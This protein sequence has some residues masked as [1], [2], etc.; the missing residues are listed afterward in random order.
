MASA[1][2]ANTLRQELLGLVRKAFSGILDL[3]QGP[4]KRRFFFEN[5]QLLAAQSSAPG[6]TLCDSLAA[7]GV[8]SFDQRDQTLQ[9]VRAQK[10]SVDAA[11]LALGFITADKLAP[12]QSRHALSTLK[13]AVQSGATFQPTQRL[14]LSAKLKAIPVDATGVLDVR[15]EAIDIEENYARMR[16]QDFYE[17]L[18]VEEMATPDQVRQAYFALAKRW[19]SDRFSGIPLGESQRTLEHL[20]GLV[21]EANATLS[22][23]KK[24]ADYDLVRAAQKQGQQTDVRAIVNAEEAFHH[25]EALIERGQFEAALPELTQALQLNPNEAEFQAAYGLAI[26]FAKKDESAA[27]EAL[28]KALTLSDNSARVHEYFGRVHRALDHTHEARKHF[29]AA[30]EINPKNIWAQRELRL[31]NMRATKASGPK[32]PQ[33]KG[34]FG[35]LKK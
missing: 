6:E 7:E 3:E 12:A 8:L 35:F 14:G 30:L 1:A 20:F 16:T 28:S 25:A 34:L 31:M 32:A 26:F 19:H 29:L 23:A 22:D 17:R 5:G 21:A 27:L 9:R 10:E 18:G 2:D 11:L 33:P 13:A 4:L 24:R 15:Q